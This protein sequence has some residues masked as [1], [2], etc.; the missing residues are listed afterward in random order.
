MTTVGDVVSDMPLRRITRNYG[1]DATV[2]NQQQTI[3]EIVACLD[4]YHVIG[5]VGLPGS[6]KSLAA[7]RLAEEWRLHGGVAVVASGDDYQ[8]A[9][10]YFPFHQAITQFNVERDF[11]TK[12]ASGALAK[13][14]SAIP[15]AG[16]LAGYV[17]EKMF[18]RSQVVA[19]GT[20]L[21]PKFRRTKHPLS[22]AAHRGQEKAAFHLRRF[23]SLG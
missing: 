8:K 15:I 22:T 9:R 6:G 4:T 18:A 11:L 19:T 2:L 20:V 16:P 17:I 14:A 21:V 23:A 3:N 10:H 5:I 12:A 1:V 13:T 7:R